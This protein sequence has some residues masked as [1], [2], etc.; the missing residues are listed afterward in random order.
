MK[1]LFLITFLLCTLI[2]FFTLAVQPS[3]IALSTHLKNVSNDIKKELQTFSQTNKKLQKK[4]GLDYTITTNIFNSFFD[5]TSLTEIFT[6]IEQLWLYLICNYMKTMYTVN[7]TDAATIQ[8]ALAAL[9]IEDSYTAQIEYIKANWKIIIKPLLIQYCSPT[10]T[11]TSDEQMN[12]LILS[13]DSLSIGYIL[14]N[15]K[16]LTPLLQDIEAKIDES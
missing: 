11:R 16:I 6:K 15:T 12:D 8:L 2:P 4:L 3:N 9:H 13:D 5:I 14:I 10:D 7:D 1:K